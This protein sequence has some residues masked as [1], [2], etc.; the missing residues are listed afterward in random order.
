MRTKTIKPRAKEPTIALINIV[1]LMLI[2]FMIAGTLAGPIDRKVS[3]IKTTD[4]DGREPPDAL[5]IYAD[6]TLHL[7]GVIVTDATAYLAELTTK[8]R[9][10][11]RIVPDRDLPAHKL[12]GIG[13]AL[14]AAG[15]ERVMLVSEKAL[16]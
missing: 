5:V 2:F 13:S 12:V 6:G 15:A 3:L 9:A 10:V 1:F 16:P 7:R 4:I 8:E 11:V 14:R